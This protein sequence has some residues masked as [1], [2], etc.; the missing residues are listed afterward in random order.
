MHAYDE[1]VGILQLYEIWEKLAKIVQFNND[2]KPVSADS[3][4]PLWIN[5]CVTRRS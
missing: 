3:L 4:E 2:K 1:L 5:P